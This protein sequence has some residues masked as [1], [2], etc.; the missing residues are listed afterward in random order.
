ME[1][2]LATVR[3]Q[4]GLGGQRE[5]LLDRLAQLEEPTIVEWGTRDKVLPYAKAKEAVSRL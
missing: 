1:A 5:V 4:V 2:Q 3:A